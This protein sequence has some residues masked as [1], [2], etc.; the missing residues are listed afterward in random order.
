MADVAAKRTADIEPD[1]RHP[2]SPDAPAQPPPFAWLGPAIVAVVVCATLLLTGARYGFH[3][4]ELYH[5]LLAQHPAWGYADTGPALPLLTHAAVS[6]FGATP[7]AVRVPAAL[8]AAITVLLVALIARE[9]GGSARAQTFAAVATAASAFVLMIGHDLLTT[10]LDEPLTLLALLFVLRALRRSD[11]RWWLAVGAVFGIAWYNKYV[12]VLTGLALVIGLVVAGPR[13]TFG[14]RYLWL[15]LL[16]AVVVGAPN[17]VFQLTH[18][19]VEFHMAS[20]LSA[21]NGTA[22]RAAILPTQLTL[23]GPLLL[24]FWII[25][26]IRLFRTPNVRSMGIAYIAFLVLMLITAPR[27]DYIFPFQLV[28]LAAGC[29]SV[30]RWLAERPVRQLVVGAAVVLNAAL[31]VVISLPVIPVQQLANALPVNTTLLPDQA[32]LVADQV[33]WPEYT[34]EVAAA[35]RSLP[36]ADRSHTVLL[37]GNY[38]EAGA[39][40][41]L[42]KSYDLPPVYS[43]HNQIFYYG[44]P[45][46]SATTVIFSEIKAGLPQLEGAF[47]HCYLFSRVTNTYGV[48]NEERGNPIDICQ[49]LHGSWAQIWPS[50]RHF[51]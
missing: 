12:I 10:S 18:N 50:L 14:Q 26:L 5:I 35:Y 46:Q 24:P 32:Q 43:G 2:S 16:I 30:D 3:R 13:A 27:P 15:G 29:I 8:L 41:L 28:A 4:D 21:R 25:G 20:A 44:P 7:W 36:A 47:D 17:L 37:T 42:G 11:G 33:G 6:I 39:L 22:D 31:S 45:P 19:V 9:L 49:G 48:P 38:G 34:A 40:E 23:I 51:D 1:P